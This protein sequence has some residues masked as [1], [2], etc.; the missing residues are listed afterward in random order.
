MLWLEGLG[1]LKNLM[2]SLGIELEVDSLSLLDS[3]QV[4][5]IE[6][7]AVSVSLALETD[8]FL[9]LLWLPKVLLMSMKSDWCKCMSLR[10]PLLPKSEYQCK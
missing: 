3:V 2:I 5:R 6:A 9:L 7:L 4:G 1:Q 10:M 8:E